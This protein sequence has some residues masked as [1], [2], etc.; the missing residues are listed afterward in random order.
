M[1]VSQV[2]LVARMA[3]GTV[4]KVAMGDLPGRGTYPW[5]GTD[6]ALDSGRSSSPH[7]Y[8]RRISRN[9]REA[10]PG[11]KLARLEP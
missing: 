5:N 3:D 10:R 8:G 4:E 2:L 6:R 9:P 11:E 7:D 1:I